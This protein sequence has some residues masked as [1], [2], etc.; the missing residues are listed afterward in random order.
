MYIQPET[1]DNC[2]L[3]LEV[4]DPSP[5]PLTCPVRNHLMTSKSRGLLPSY[6]HL[7]VQSKESKLFLDPVFGCCFG[8]LKNKFSAHWDS[9][10][11]KPQRPLRGI[12]GFRSRGVIFTRKKEAIIKCSGKTKGLHF[13]VTAG[14]NLWCGSWELIWS[15]RTS[16][17]AFHTLPKQARHRNISDRWMFP[18]ISTN[19]CWRA[20]SHVH[21]MSP[22]KCHIQ[23]IKRWKWRLGNR[24]NDVT[25]HDPT[26][27]PLSSFSSLKSEIP[28][29][30]SGGFVSFL[31]KRLLGFQFLQWSKK[32]KRL[33]TTSS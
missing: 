25:L 15:L 6:Q 5:N 11:R 33:Q 32:K 14:Q 17:G 8:W 1:I 18:S 28:L 4:L 10:A 21:L 24:T 26:R 3:H 29:D 7:H 12:W 19:I 20:E 22:E 31:D 9:P 23:D 27:A 30:L 2:A 13:F 16:K